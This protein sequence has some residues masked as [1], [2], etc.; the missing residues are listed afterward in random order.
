MKYKVAASP[1]E[2]A[3][4]I[5]KDESAEFIFRA[6]QDMIV[7]PME[8]KKVRVETTS[9]AQSALILQIHPHRNVSYEAL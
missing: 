9:E 2:K 6:T 1:R 4:I 5:E 8:L 3:R 7:R